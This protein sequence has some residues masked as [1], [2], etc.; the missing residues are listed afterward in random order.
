MRFVMRAGL[1]PALLSMLVATQAS[2]VVLYS[3]AQRNI[4]P[5]GSLLNHGPAG[6]PRGTG[7][8]RRLLN[9]GWQWQGE[10]GGFLGTPIAPQF[11]ITAKHIAGSAGH[12]RLN[13]VNYPI[14]TT[15]GNGGSVS[16]PNADLIIYKIQGTFP[17]FAPLYNAATDGSEVG[18]SLVFIG[19]GTQRGAEVRVNSVLKGW[20]WGTFDEVQ[21]WGENQ[22]AGIFN[23]GPQYGDLLY[24]DFD[25][26]GG[27]NEGALTN[28]DSGGGWFIQS[29]GTWKLSAISF[30]V[31]GPFRYT[32]S[33]PAFNGALF[34]MGGLWIGD[35]TPQFIPDD[36]MDVPSSSYGTR[37]S[38]NLA[39]I[40]LVTGAS[41][42]PEPSIG[43]LCLAITPLL[44]RR[45]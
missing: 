42:T 19:R 31:D 38:S 13:S 33:G 1:T 40:Q 3:S 28:G 16:N 18:K 44:G 6:D 14:D 29:N 12:L 21:S 5:P 9:S 10:F 30:T 25:A 20:E 26:D 39:W 4:H 45:R 2:A 34:D 17:T 35:P 7:D 11:F 41:I 32:Q 23:F 8:P 37:I 36:T 24:T 27:P 22:A 15:F 43:L